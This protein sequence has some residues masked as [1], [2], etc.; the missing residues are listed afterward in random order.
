MSGIVWIASYPKSGNT[1]FRAFMSNLRRQTEMPVSINALD[2]PTASNRNMF[3]DVLGLE[4]SDLTPEEIECLFPKVFEHLVS[5]TDE[6]LF[7]K[8]HDAYV[9]TTNNLPLI[10]TKATKSAIYILRN[11]LDVAVSFAHHENEDIN[12]I[13]CRMADENEALASNP[14]RLSLPLRQRLLSWSSHVQSWVNNPNFP[15]HLIRYE[16]MHQQAEETFTNTARFAGLSD[17]PQQIQQALTFSTFD[18][19]KNQEQEQGYTGK[20]SGAK[21]FFRQGQVGTWRNVLTDKQ[22]NLIIQNHSKTMKQYGYLTSDGSPV[23]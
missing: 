1:W 10:S 5:N 8:I 6:T 20:A 15:V 22:I 9:L 2:A 16:D 13:I 18:K 23:F 11:P 14:T 3:D 19:L 21:S 7:F 17:N 12:R 4:T